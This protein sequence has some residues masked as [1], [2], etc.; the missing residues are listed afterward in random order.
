MPLASVYSPATTRTCGRVEKVGQGGVQHRAETRGRG[1]QVEM[2]QRRHKEAAARKL[3]GPAHLCRDQH[4]L[5]AS[6]GKCVWC[7]GGVSCWAEG[8]GWQQPGRPAG[9]SPCSRAGCPRRT[10]HSPIPPACCAALQRGSRGNNG[11]RK[12]QAGQAGLGKR[13]AAA[14]EGGRWRSSVCTWCH[15]HIPPPCI[16]FTSSSG[17]SSS[18]SSPSCMKTAS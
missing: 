4:R 8:R 2:G 9:G 18:S 12:W 7:S 1:E 13:R 6:A 17:A 11:G 3:V 15:S 10:A 14:A 5:R 16:N